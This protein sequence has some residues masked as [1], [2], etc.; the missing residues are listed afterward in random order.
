MER[1]YDVTGLG[2]ILIDFIP[3]GK[4][5]DGDLRF[6]RKAG[7]APLNLLATVSKFG[8]KAAFIGKVGND[9]FGRYLTDT[10]RSCGI[11][12]KGLKTDP[13]RNTTLAFVSLS[14]DGDREFS[15]CRKYGA[16]TALSRADVDADLIAS[17]RIFHF[18]SLSFTDPVCADASRYAIDVAKNAGCT[19]T[20]DPNYRAPLW[21]D[22]VTAVAAMRE[23]FPYADFVKVSREEAELLTG[24]TDPDAQM[25]AL[26]SG[27]NTVVLVTDGGNGVHYALRGEHGF[28]PSLPVHPVDTTGAGDIFFG[29]FLTCWLNGGKT[30]EA[31]TLGD[32]TDYVKHAISVSGRSTLKHGA[33]ASIPNSMEEE[34]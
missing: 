21:R 33:I 11:D 4:D 2:E 28:L 17:S 25:N 3:D 15:F 9:L 13:D 5:P 29:T 19:V 32:V 23:N 30:K 26:I 24:K 14:E 34:K 7:G 22:Q 31:L 12:P 18:G 1:N 8:G 16:D 27:G 20:Y 10:V 6:I